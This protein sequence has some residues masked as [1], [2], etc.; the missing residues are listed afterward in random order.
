M[1]PVKTVRG[2]EEREIEE[3][4]GRDELNYDIL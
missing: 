3:T 4:E 1:R 2:M